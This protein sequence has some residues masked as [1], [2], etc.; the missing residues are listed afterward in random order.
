[1]NRRTRVVVM[2]LAVLAVA[3]VALGAVGLTRAGDDGESPAPPASSAPPASPAPT[4]TSPAPATTDAPVAPAISPLVLAVSVDGLNPQA[5]TMLGAREVPNLRR[6][7]AEGASTLNARTAHELTITLPNHTGMLTGRGVAG[8]SGHGVTFNDDTGGTLARTHGSYVPGIF[9]I[10]HDHGL[11]T[12]FFAEKDKFGFL[13]RS[14]NRSNGAPD[15]TG[16]DDGRDKTDIDQVGDAD[17][18][19]PEV[20][21]A[22]LDPDTGLVFLH[23]ADPDRAGHADG[24]LGASYL[25][26]VRSVDRQLGSILTVIDS[27]AET[28]ERV[29]ILLTADHG[30]VRG[31]TSHD[32][33]A[34]LSNHRVPFIAWGRGVARGADLYALNAARTN[35]GDGR[36]GYGGAQP[37]RNIDIANAAL[38]LLDLPR[39]PGATSSDWPVLRFQ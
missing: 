37:V 7:I 11:G 1:M 18:L 8:A 15:T 39:L 28:R 12:A 9:D 16:T 35:P 3:A 17:A 22:L 31:A 34:R 32:D 14:W 20:G 24:W 6:L 2:V 4:S 26:A 5:L 38:S 33:P 19:L 23:L 27:S 29:T 13:S 10:A 30:G 36:P 25:D 21:R